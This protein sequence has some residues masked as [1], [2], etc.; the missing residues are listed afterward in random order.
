MQ[1]ERNGIKE[2]IE[3]ILLTLIG[4]LFFNYYEIV[5]HI[6]SLRGKDMGPWLHTRLD[7]TVPYMPIFI[8]PYVLTWMIP[9]FVNITIVKKSGLPALRRG[10]FAFLGLLILLFSFYI[11]LPSSTRLNLPSPLSISQHAFSTSMYFF[12]S[13][14]SPWNAFPSNHVAISWFF[15]RAL[16][17]YIT[18][19][20][21]LMYQTWFWIMFISTFSIKIHY[22]AD[23]IAG[24]IFAEC[25]YRLIRFLLINHRICNWN[26]S[27]LKICIGAY[28]LLATVLG[29]GLWT[30]M[31]ID[32]FTTL[33]NF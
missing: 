18:K 8:F 23:S 17:P 33:H 25:Y 11:F 20:I 1:W 22:I 28:F 4:Y 12:Y 30:T 16:K 26:W 6:A 5:A 14:I 7:D 21:I 9:I 13:F 24:L 3:T 2:G 19:P 10:M 31:P 15:Y 32:G 29:V 27:S